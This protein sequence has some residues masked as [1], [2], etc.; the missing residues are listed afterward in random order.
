M[1][2][3]Q[4][5]GR[6]WINS[7]HQV[8]YTAVDWDTAF[9]IYYCAWVKYSGELFNP[10]LCTLSESCAHY[11]VEQHTTVCNAYLGNGL[12][13]LYSLYSS[14]SS[15]C[16]LRP[17]TESP[18]SRTL[19]AT[20]WSKSTG[21]FMG[22]NG[23]QHQPGP[24]EG[25]HVVPQHPRNPRPCPGRPDTPCQPA[26]LDPGAF[27][28]SVSIWALCCISSSK[29]KPS[30]AAGRRWEKFTPFKGFDI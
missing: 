3:L 24:S 22:R 18:A 10:I 14:V 16:K 15:P 27:A 20:S 26:P 30:A 11:W 25:S 5:C 7:N 21:L 9:C 23:A 8:Q 1:R 2:F 28:S 13:L 12:I 6:W 29:A 4:T 19:S 17:R